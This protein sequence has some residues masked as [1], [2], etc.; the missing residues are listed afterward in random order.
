MKK[1]LYTIFLV[2]LIFLTFNLLY[3]FELEEKNSVRIYDRN[4]VLLYDLK[5]NEQRS[6]TYKKLED[7]PW[8]I[9]EMVIFRE[10]KRFYRHFWIDLIGIIR[11]SYKNIKHLKIV[12]WAS[13]IDS[14]SI[15]LSEQ[16]YKRSFLQKIREFFFAVNLNFHYTKDQI[17]LYYINNLP[18]GG[19][20][21]WF[22]S[23]CNIYYWL[24][25]SL[26]NKWKLV[27]LFTISKFWKKWNYYNDAYYFSKKLWL[28]N[29]KK[30]DYK[31]FYRK[32]WFHIKNKA[33]FF[34][35]Y[36]I[37]TQ[38]PQKSTKTQFDI[39]IYKKINSILNS[40]RN[41]LNNMSVHDAC[42]LVLDEQRKIVSMNLLRK[43]GKWEAWFVNWCLSPRQVWSAIK[44]FWYLFA[45]KKLSLN[46]DDKILDAPVKYTLENG[47]EY[48]PKNFSLNYNWEVSLSVAL[49]S[50]LNIPAVK[51]L[52]KSWL[53]DYRDFL[54]NIWKVVWTSDR[55]VEDYNKY[56]LSLALGTKE[57]SLLDFAKMRT[58]F[59]LDK[60]KNK[61]ISENIFYKKYGKDIYKIK[62]ILWN[63]ENRSISF[64][65][66]SW[67]NVEWS[68][69]KTW[70]SRH[71][72]DW[73]A[74]WWVKNY[75][76]CVWTWNYNASPASAS[77]IQ[78]AWII[79]NS[80]AKLM[81]NDW[82][83]KK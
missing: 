2:L 68:F 49:W 77:A 45:F 8:F 4:W 71:F 36:Y 23:A 16:A 80:V 74:C 52:E 70:T 41:Y 56:G 53:S 72:K 47:G 5:Q 67:I 10:D 57:I 69:A 31:R 21:R 34:I 82:Y 7:V 30:S 51:L 3:K 65:R 54:N 27:S 81:L 11:A 55:W 61:S 78:T 43:Y 1:I 32:M 17:L 62:K 73:V 33:A 40:Y 79:R 76:V 24:S 37:K 42:V 29:Y 26:L 59:I 14:Q 38:K 25:C 48:S 22:K 58:V 15:K 18:F 64:G 75:I 39:S 60:K 13:T 19:G 12:Q 9:K 66:N 83:F 35:Q 50:S 28:K 46:K 6:H 20:V 63:N 44:P